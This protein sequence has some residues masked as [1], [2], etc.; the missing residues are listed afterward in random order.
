M[1][2]TCD[3]CGGDLQINMGGQGAT[4]TTCGLNYTMDRLREML[5]GS[6]LKVETAKQETPVVEP[7]KIEIPTP[8]PLNKDLG[9]G[10]RFNYKPESFAMEVTKTGTASVL[11]RVQ[12]GGIGLGDR[13]YINNDY[14]NPYTVQSLKDATLWNAKKG[15]SVQLYLKKCPRRILK[16]ATVITG[17][18][19]PVANAYN[20]QGTVNEYFESLLREEFSQFEIRKDVKHR[21]LELPVSF[22]LSQNGKPLLAVFLIHSQ[23]SEESRMLRAASHV[24]K[25]MGIGCTHFYK[26]YRNDASYVVERV[27]NEIG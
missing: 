3:L 12:K 25:R 23:D 10:N 5:N 22:L 1:K 13:V 9:T 24:L 17:D 7:V 6:G 26:N 11:G 21:E 2:L 20:Y 15:M 16:K 8:I 27:R 14:K 18:P 19:H 4:C